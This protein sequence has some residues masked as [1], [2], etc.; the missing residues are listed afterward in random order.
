MEKLSDHLYIP[1]MGKVLEEKRLAI[2]AEKKLARSYAASRVNRLNSG[3]TTNPTAAN[4]EIRGGIA[5]LR[6]RSRQASRDSGHIS[7]FLRLMRAN[8]IGSKGIQLQSRARVA[9]TSK[10][11]VDLNKQI[12]ER[13]FEWTHREYCTVSNKLNFVGVQ[14]LAL[15]QML[16][17]GEFLI[18]MIQ[19]DGGF[20]LW[21]KVWDVNWL[22]ETFN[23]N[24]PGVNRIIMS[25]EV[26]DNDKPVGYWLTP[27][28][29]ETEHLPAGQTRRRIR[30]SADQM[31]HGYLIE[32][33]ESQVRSVAWLTPAL[34]DIKHFD[35][36]TEGVVTSARVAANTFGFV[37]QDITDGEQWTGEEDEN[38]VVMQPQITSSPLSVNLLNPG[39]D[40]VQF[41]PKQ[42]TQNHPAFSKVM[43]TSIGT[44]LGVPYFLLV[45]DWEAVNY[46]SSRGGLGEFH[47]MCQDLQEFISEIMHRRI[48]HTWLREAWL[49]KKLDI[50]AKQYFELQ[51]PT[52]RGRGWDYIDPTKDV[53]A[54]VEQLKNRLATPSELLAKRGVDYI[55]FLERWQSDRDTAA[56]YGV[57]IEE[58]Y[59][60][61]PKQL[62]AAPDD[63]DDPPDD[64][65][66]PKKP[67]DDTDGEE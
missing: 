66:P 64:D 5:A 23:E 14:R 38:G 58:I 31:I 1:P 6:A 49:T 30:I 13:W 2:A 18:Q 25:V 63:G 10:L 54:D 15:T 21:L 47:Q 24:R 45:G 61:Q 4:Y 42:P 59:S 12:E 29:S 52:W 9:G 57:D 39:Q 44:D 11:D 40:F 22:D 37:K 65:E 51:N 48:Y 43:Q 16:R 7:N 55:D 35:G 26:D 41:D 8:V 19:T 3:W 62:A 17:D 46:S 33:D 50:T 67:A 36:Y 34:L 53:K 20:G 27:P 60:E 56:Q 32:D 28:P